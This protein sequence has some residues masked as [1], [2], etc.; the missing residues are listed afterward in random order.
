LNSYFK[1][2]FLL[3]FLLVIPSCTMEKRLYQKGYH[4]E[5]KKKHSGTHSRETNDLV[6][7]GETEDPLEIPVE[8]QEA[9]QT[10]AEKTADLSSS[11]ETKTTYSDNNRS[12][13]IEAEA[14]PNEDTIFVMPPNEEAVKE[15]QAHELR[16]YD[17][18]TAFIVL[19]ILALIVLAF[20]AINATITQ[21]SGV[22]IL[23]MLALV[24]LVF[25]LIIT[26]VVRDQNRP[27]N[28]DKVRERENRK[29]KVKDPE[30]EKEQLSPEEAAAKKSKIKKRALVFFVVLFTFIGAILILGNN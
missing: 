12:S 17:H 20:V 10:E 5:W 9:A 24:P 4:L 14:P 13:E 1:F 3:V 25:I 15:A 27:D 11:E 21:M 22:A 18:V 7:A 8:K 26:V 29:K 23:F 30:E 2:T 6:S 16:T 19:L 28:P